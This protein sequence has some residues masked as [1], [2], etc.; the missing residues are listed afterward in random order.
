MR[1]TQKI[2]THSRRGRRVAMQPE[3]VEFLNISIEIESYI[4][5]YSIRLKTSSN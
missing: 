1:S 3:I 4:D 2:I 5:R